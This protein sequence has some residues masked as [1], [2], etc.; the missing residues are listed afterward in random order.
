MTQAKLFNLIY[1]LKKGQCYR[2]SE[3]QFRKAADENFNA[4]DRPYIEEG[5]KLF[6][7]L[8][9]ENWG[10]RLTSNIFDQSITIE[11]I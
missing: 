5:R 11:K 10:V 3:Y 4:L 2:L 9:S 1:N 6:A 7:Q 8:I